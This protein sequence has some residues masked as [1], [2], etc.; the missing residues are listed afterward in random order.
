MDAE[1]TGL[2]VSEIPWLGPGNVDPS[3]HVAGSQPLPASYSALVVDKP[4]VMQ[5]DQCYHKNIYL[6]LILRKQ[7]GKSRRLDVSKGQPACA[8]KR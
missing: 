2:Q 5:I 8:F 4:D 3:N 1:R 7:S 6:N